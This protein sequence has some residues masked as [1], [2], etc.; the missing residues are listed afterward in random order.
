MIEIADA[1]QYKFPNGI[2]QIFWIQNGENN[3]GYEILL[4]LKKE[5]NQHELLGKWSFG[6]EVWSS[7]V[8]DQWGVY[9]E[10]RI[11]ELEEDQ[12]SLDEFI[13]ELG[14]IDCRYMLFNHVEPYN[15]L[16]DLEVIKQLIA[17]L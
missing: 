8:W 10:K 9:I 6:H 13:D 15:H 17:E 16:E 14:G 5:N 2:V 12:E 7:N 11:K 4:E 1:V 3:C